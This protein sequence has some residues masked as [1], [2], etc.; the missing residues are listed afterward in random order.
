M[1]VTLDNLH[2]NDSKLEPEIVET[3][4]FDEVIE[5]FNA[6]IVQNKLDP[7]SIDIGIK[8]AYQVNGGP[9]ISQVLGYINPL[10]MSVNISPTNLVFNAQTIENILS[11]AKAYILKRQ[12]M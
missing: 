11:D 12:N 9:W 8:I 2:I 1:S 3:L 10:G 6:F 4:R 7:R 5:L